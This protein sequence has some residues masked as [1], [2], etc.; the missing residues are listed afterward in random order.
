MSNRFGA[1]VIGAVAVF[2]FLFTVGENRAHADSVLTDAQRQDLTNSRYV[3]ISSQRKDGNFGSP[4]EIWFLFHDEAV[5][6]GTTP[7]SWRARRIKAG[8]TDAK[9]AVGKVDGPSFKAKGAIVKDPTVEELMFTTFA[10][11]YPD[12]WP[13]HEQK[14]RNGF[15]DGR[16]ILIKYT[17]VK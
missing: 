6:V 10:K 1:F 11:K 4:A 15:K 16:R 13:N 12:G 5:W 17:P 7:E 2:G 8:R 14:F 3:Y 9:I